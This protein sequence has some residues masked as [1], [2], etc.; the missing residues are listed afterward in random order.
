M[1]APKVLQ[2]AKP[3]GGNPNMTKGKPNGS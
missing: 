3:T 1:A 2:K